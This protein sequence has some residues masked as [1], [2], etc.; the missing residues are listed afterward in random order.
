MHCKNSLVFFLFTLWCITMQSA[1]AQQKDVWHVFT[2]KEGYK[3]GFKDAAGRIR[4]APRFMGCFAATDFVHVIAA[5]E[6]TKAGLKSYYLLKNG[7]QFGRD[8]MYVFDFTFD[9]ESEGFIRFRDPVT[10]KVGLFNSVGGIGIPALYSDM[11]RVQNGV[12]TALYGAMRQ[13]ADGDSMTN[14]EHWYWTG[15]RSLLLDST[16]H[17]LIEDFKYTDGIDYF[18]MRVDVVPPPDTTRIVFKG[19]N[20]RYYSFVDNEK[21][22]Q[23]FVADTFLK[24]NTAP[25]IISYCYPYI[26]YANA[27]INQWTDKPAHAFIQ[28][29]YISI[30]KS[31]TLIKDRNH[32]YFTS[33][34]DDT[35]LTDKVQ[36]SL[37]KKY[38]D[39]G[40][41][42]GLTKSFFELIIEHYKDSTGN[43]LLQDQLIFIKIPGGFKLI[44]V[45]IQSA[46]IR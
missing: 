32:N 16:N 10:D 12:V 39:G 28:D 38:N 33:L 41:F 45:D 18:S 24:L 13:C 46:P 19:T 34:T 5:M 9:T 36:K 17:V 20:E 4:I 43:N 35:P 25:D 30:K 7:K 11:G 21:R 2:D 3:Y 40:R 8:S 42:N 29:N 1:F 23:Q 6:E 14:C 26:V 27:H 31:I 15:G 22:F 37:Q 44:S